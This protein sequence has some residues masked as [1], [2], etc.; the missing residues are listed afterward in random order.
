[1]HQ[2]KVIKNIQYTK[3]NEL[4]C[5]IYLPESKKLNPVII[6]LFG[7]GWE[8]GNKEMQIPI[9]QSLAKEGFASLAID[10]RL[11]PKHKFPS[12]IT[13]I[14]SA[15]KFI[16]EN[17]KKYNFDETK[18]CISG[19]SAGGT[20]AVIAGMT[21]HNYSPKIRCAISFHGPMD[22][23]SYS[24][25]SEWAQKLVHQLIGGKLS[26][27]FNNAKKASPY[28]LVNS[29]SSAMLFIASKYDKSVP[30]EYAEKTAEKLMEFNVLVNFLLHDSD[31]HGNIDPDE[32]GRRGWKDMWSKENPPK[33]MF[34]E[35]VITF[36]KEN[37]V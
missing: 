23:V 15:L 20:L 9:S 32:V 13:D 3:N 28:H 7:G 22:L 1:M 5:D 24:Q 36:L 29:S 34:H 14:K 37:L 27:L 2:F 19:L 33:I 31:F 21:L 11:A 6:Q 17:S 16:Q 8:E 4:Y 35:E 18:I 25:Y 26:E 30:Y 12:Q 10:Y